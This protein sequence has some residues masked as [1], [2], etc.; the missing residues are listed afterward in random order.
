MKFDA[1]SFDDANLVHAILC[2][3]DYIPL[4]NVYI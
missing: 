4:K 1:L 2:Q 3:A